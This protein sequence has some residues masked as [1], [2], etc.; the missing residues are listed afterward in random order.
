MIDLKAAPVPGSGRD[1]VGAERLARTLND[2]SGSMTSVGT[3]VWSARRSAGGDRLN[4]PGHGG[5]KGGAGRGSR[6][7]RGDG[8]FPARG[9]V[10]SGRQP[11]SAARTRHAER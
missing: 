5:A 1:P 11:V 2:S 4:E 9:T 10:R 3:G 7:D 8:G 6:T